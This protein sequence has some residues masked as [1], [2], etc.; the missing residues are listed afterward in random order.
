MLTL[1]LRHIL[2]QLEGVHAAAEEDRE[3]GL[4]QFDQN[5][6]RCALSA[7]FNLKFWFSLLKGRD[8]KD[9]WKEKGEGWKQTLYFLYYNLSL[10]LVR[11]LE[12]I[13]SEKVEPANVEKMPRNEI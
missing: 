12:K 2:I 1:Q 10:L 11:L 8:E 9:T 4:I 3:E 5:N 7:V 6:L 13:L